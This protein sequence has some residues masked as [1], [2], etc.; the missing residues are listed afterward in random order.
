MET[1]GKKENYVQEGEKEE[2]T[3][4]KKEKKKRCH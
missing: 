3:A 1:E 2:M 4:I